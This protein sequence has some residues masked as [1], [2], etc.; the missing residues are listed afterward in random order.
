MARHE[1]FHVTSYQELTVPQLL[2][3]A[4]TLRQADEALGRLEKIDRLSYRAYKTLQQARVAIDKMKNAI[5][6]DLIHRSKA[7]IQ[8]DLL[9][10]ACCQNPPLTKVECADIIR[11]FGSDDRCWPGAHIA[12]ATGVAHIN[13]FRQS[14]E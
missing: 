11:R 8:I 2:F 3:H 10:R 4:V 1:P 12:T 6:C 5:T 7:G 9:L 13:S 14:A